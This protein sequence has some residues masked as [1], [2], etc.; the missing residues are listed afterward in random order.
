MYLEFGHDTTID[1]AL[2]ALGLAKFE[3]LYLP[4]STANR[5]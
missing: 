4:L 1:M 3:H 2:T 5:A